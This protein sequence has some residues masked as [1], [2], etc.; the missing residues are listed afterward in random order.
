MTAHQRTGLLVLALA[1]L[2]AAPEAKGQYFG[3]NKVRYHEHNFKVLKTTHFD[4]YYYPQEKQAADQAGRMAERWYTRF[5][6]IFKTQLKGRQP[7]ILYGSHPEFAQTTVTPQII[8]AGTGGFTE[9]L[10]RRVVMPLAGPLGET[11]HVLGHELVHAFQFNM[12]PM[13]GLGEMSNASLPL[14]FI[15]GMAEYL[16]LGPADPNTT[17]WIR[18][19]VQRRDVPAIK[20]LDKPKYFPYRW[21]QAFWAF[22]GGKYGDKAVGDMM[23]IGAVN[24][25]NA[26]IQSVLK[27]NEKQLS[28]DWK[29]ALLTSGEPVLHDTTPVTE[30]GRVLVHEQEPGAINV[31]PSVSPDGKQLMLFSEKGLFSIELYLADAQTGEIKKKIT[32]T[33]LSPH[34]NNLE[35]INSSG[36]W[37]A[38][39]SQF[40]YGHV[41]GPNAEISIYDLRKDEVVRTIPLPGLGEVFSPTWSPDGRQ[42]AFSAIAGGLTNLYAVDVSSGKMRQLTNDEYAE[43]QP[44]WS[45]DGKTIAYVTDRFTADLQNLSFGRFGLALFDVSS[46]NSRELRTFDAGK[47]IDPHWSADGSTIFFISDRAGISDIYRISLGDH[48]IRQITDLQTGASGI[49]DLSPA[50]SVSTT[51]QRL[52]FSAFHDSGY[53]ILALEGNRDL[54]GERPDTRVASLSAG[55]LPPRQQ[56]TGEVPSLLNSPEQGLVSAAGFKTKP[57]SAGLS[58]DYIAPPSVAVGFSSFGNLVA[59]GTAFHFSDM[60]GYHDLTLVAQTGIATQGGHFLRNLSAQALYLNHRSRWNWGFFGGQ[61]PYLTGSFGATTGTVSGEPA[62]VEQQVTFWQIERQAGGVLQYPFNRAQR[63]EFD[64]G[65][66]NIAFAAEADTQAVSLIDGSLL[67]RGT[68]NLPSPTSLN[69]AE[70]DAA[71]VDDTS[72][73]GGVAPVAG[74]RYRLQAGVAGGSL[75]FY[76]L[77]GDYRRY[78]HI[79]R[80]LSF[81]VR[82]LHYGRYG[83]GAEDQRIQEFF[84]GY[85]SLIRGYDANS[86]SISEC[87]PQFQQTGTCPVFDRLVGSRLLVGNAELRLEWLGPLGIIPHT[88]R[89]PPVHTAFFFDAGEAWTSNQDAGFLGGPRHGV[90]SEG[91]A[92]RFNVFGAFVGEVSA[93]HPNDRPGK[94]WI[95]Q[96][97]LLPGF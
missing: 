18:D 78:F 91:I 21:G 58:L 52:I 40:A 12:I 83:G 32:S 6:T 45:P 23:R 59:G 62:L 90:S 67:A 48:G 65:Y 43:L 30:A 85:P 22:V 42:I 50:I 13:R 47:S 49:T 15:E 88:R 5:S 51:S 66:D 61:V 28:K 55:I 96:F 35:F 63:L 81:A 97:S 46:G 60:L 44:A 4:I 54:A 37:S 31:S 26:A 39:S 93:A 34:F 24:G 2:F 25:V 94:N 29:A 17:M 68:Q 92:L 9:P 84:I 75:N 11:N 53:E 74:Q 72:L 82:A 80:P 87:G 56:D 8:G 33:A 77:L 1:L 10:R 73:F 7:V 95:W 76:T 79:A 89:I 69:L 16:S 86:F 3:Q 41:T 20:D 38:D 64:A 36:S 14:W 71:F 19:A 57:Y 27:T 70:G